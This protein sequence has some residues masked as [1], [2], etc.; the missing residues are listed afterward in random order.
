MA[1][2]TLSDTT[3]SDT[4]VSD[5]SVSDN[6]P[7]HGGTGAHVESWFLRANHPTR[8]LALWLKATILRPVRGEA[9]AEA[10]CLAFDGEAGRTWGAR[11]TVPLTRAR[12]EGQPLQ[13]AVG[14][15]QF[16]L[17]EAGG[18]AQGALQGQQGTARW[19]LAWQAVSGAAGQ[20]LC[21]FPD[22]KLLAG[23]FPRSKLVT[24]LP[25][26]RFEGSLDLGEGEIPIDGWLGMQGHNWG[27]EHAPQY[28]W[29]Q[30]LFPTPDG[31]EPSMVEGFS[32]RI[33]LAGLTTPLLSMLVVRHQGQEHRFDR[34]A[35]SWRP[36]A[37]VGDLSWSL[38]IAG[39]AGRAQLH[40]QARPQQLVCLGYGNPDGRLSYCFNSKLAH[41][42]LELQPT[43]GSPFRLDSEHGGALEILDRHPD[44]RFPDVI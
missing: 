34:L 17:G 24:P 25:C 4:S 28:A 29:G 19:K 21:I 35:T 44:P 14:G 8:P 13:A 27:R 3:L 15:C 38:D 36:K 26:A 1:A 10:W 23:G 22:R 7:R 5:T 42:S 30:C 11:E 2:P 33:R 31:G 12:F 41:T 9:V 18:R 43:T 39:P 37:T 16:E 32:A 6:A 40:M 20:A